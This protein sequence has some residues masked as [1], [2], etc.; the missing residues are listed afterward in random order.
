KEQTMTTT[1]EAVAEVDEQAVEALAGRLFQMGLST[2]EYFTVYLG[3]RLGYY[4]ALAEGSATST[5]LA[6]RTGT[7]ERY[8]GEWLEQQAVAGLIDVAG[9]ETAPAA[10][11]FSLAPAA[12]LVFVERDSPAYLA[13]LARIGGSLALVLPALLEAFRSGGGVNWADY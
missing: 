5:E 7:N 11:R 4:R 2:F 1:D 6:S 12:A 13:P 10:R 3:D 8:G 9:T